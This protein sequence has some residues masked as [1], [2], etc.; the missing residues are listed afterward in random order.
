M[1]LS[2]L[3]PIEDFI[4]QIE[5]G[6]EHDDLPVVLQKIY[7]EYWLRNWIVAYKY[8]SLPAF[9]SP[10]QAIQQDADGVHFKTPTNLS[11]ESA[12]DTFNEAPMTSIGEERETIEDVI[13]PYLIQQGFLQRTPRGRIATPSD[14]RLMNTRPARACSHFQPS[15]MNA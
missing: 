15:A 3:I 2:V 7:F 10:M 12:S 4:E 11:G 9:H 1:S 8:K 5:D 14:M 13:E 6:F